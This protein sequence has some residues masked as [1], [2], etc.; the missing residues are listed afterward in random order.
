MFGLKTTVFTFQMLMDAIIEETKI[1]RI[2]SYQDDIIDGANSFQETIENSS[3]FWNF[4][5]FLINLK[6][7]LF[8]IDKWK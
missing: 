6:I 1:E 4:F 3:C 5:S 7:M 8:M 2:F